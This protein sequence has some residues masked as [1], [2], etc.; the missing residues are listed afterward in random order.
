[1]RIILRTGYLATLIFAALAPSGSQ[2]RVPSA[3]D[4]AL[5]CRPT[6]ACTADVVPPQTTEIELGYQGR[7]I[8]AQSMHHSVPFLLKYTVWPWLQ[9][10]VA[11][12]GPSLQRKPVLREYFDDVQAGPKFHLWDQTSTLPAVAVSLAISVPTAKAPGYLRTYDLLTTAFISHDLGPVHLDLNLGFNLWRLGNPLLQ[13]WG[14]LAA[15]AQLTPMW[16]VM[17]EAYGFTSASP[18]SDADAGLLLA[19]SLAPEPWLVF[20]IGGIISADRATSQGTAFIGLTV[21]PVTWHP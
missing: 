12:N 17:A 7:F 3:S 18:V 6:V 21:I 1:M 20:D 11:S 14:A 19:V 5:P 13:Y 9:A 15:T 8:A 16:A 10:Q 2:A 4:H